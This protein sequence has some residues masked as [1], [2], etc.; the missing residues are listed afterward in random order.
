MK[1]AA[2]HFH[3]PTLIAGND[4]IRL[5]PS[6]DRDSACASAAHQP[7]FHAAWSKNA[8]LAEALERLHPERV[9]LCDADVYLPAALKQRIEAILA[10]CPERGL[11]YG[12]AGRRLCQRL[13]M[14][15]VP[16]IRLER[17]RSVIGYVQFTKENDAGPWR[18]E[19]LAWGGAHDDWRVYEQYGPERSV[20][21]PF[22]CYHVGG[23]RKHKRR[24]PCFRAEARPCM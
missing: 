7:L 9:L 20:A 4:H 2:C 3:F 15:G 12:I 16:G 24:R 18:T 23:S 17:H 11:L 1:T 8:L 19:T 6:D 5:G 13:Q 10:M 22:G 14:V 21:L